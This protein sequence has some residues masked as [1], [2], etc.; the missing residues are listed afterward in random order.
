LPEP[1]EKPAYAK[2][3]IIASAIIIVVAVIIAAAI[4]T[5]PRP[6]SPSP[7]P[8]D[9]QM[10]VLS[11]KWEQLSVAD[12]QPSAGNLYLWLKVNVTNGLEDDMIMAPMA[13]S[14]EGVDGTKHNATDD[15][16]SG[17]I[18]PDSS[19]TFNISVELPTGWVPRKVTFTYVNKVITDSVPAPS[20]MVP[21]IAF[22]NIES[23]RN[24]TDSTGH[25]QAPKDVLHVSLD[26]KNQWTKDV[27][28]IAD[29]FTLVDA[30]NNAIT[31]HIK[32]GPDMISVGSTGHLTLEFVISATFVPSAIEY[33]MGQFGPY[34][35][36]DL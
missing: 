4:I 15:D 7:E 29:T 11:A 19:A 2:P 27:D 13:F 3:H 36:V 35:S 32:T 34:G 10:D 26:L 33:D 28:T 17:F 21:D 9:I 16:S 30:S 5:A 6:A 25:S 18:D 31:V 8:L 22:S 24:S 23:F 14:V 12:K 20:A 1:E